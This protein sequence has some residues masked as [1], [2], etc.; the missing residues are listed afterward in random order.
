MEEYRVRVTKDYLVFCAAHFI[1]FDRDK[2]ECLHGHNYRVTAEIAGPLGPSYLVYDFIALKKMLREIVNRLDHRMLVP[3]RS[4]LLKV[5]EGLQRLKISS[6]DKE[7]TFPR[8]DCVLLG[9]ENTTAERLAYWIA[10]QLR[11]EMARAGL[12]PAP[13]LR[14]DVEETFGQSA[15]YETTTPAEPR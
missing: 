8:E 7:W 2:C 12:S 9:I 10:G 4:S 14:I 1:T 3:T 13:R 6:C 5:E 15:S 11:E